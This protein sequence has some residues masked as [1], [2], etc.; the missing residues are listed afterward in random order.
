MQQ[1][2]KSLKETEEWNN[3]NHETATI[4]LNTGHLQSTA[5]CA[6][7]AHPNPNASEYHQTLPL[8]MLTVIA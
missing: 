6:Y 5:D 4:V 2:K 3:A 8:Q 7:T 1:A